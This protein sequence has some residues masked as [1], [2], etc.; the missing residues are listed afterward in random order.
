MTPIFK[1]TLSNMRSIT[2]GKYQG[3]FDSVR[4]KYGADKLIILIYFYSL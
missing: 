2:S 1:E 3:I 4:N